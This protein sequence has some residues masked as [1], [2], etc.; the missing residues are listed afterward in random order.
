MVVPLIFGKIAKDIAGGEIS[1]DNANLLI[2]VVGFITAFVS[3]LFACTWMISIVKRSK[4]KYF[5]I[6]CFFVGVG[7]IIFTQING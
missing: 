6:Y 7:S 1:T 4:L 5:A 2:Y 3:G